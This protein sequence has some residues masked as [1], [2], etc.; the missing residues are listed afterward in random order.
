[1][2]A[3]RFDPQM[4]LL[5]VDLQNDFADPRGSLYVR[6]SERLVPVINDLVNEA[7]RRGALVV[8]TQDW[9]P[10]VTPHF[11]EFGGKWPAHCVAGTWGAAFVDGLRIEGPVLRKGTGEEDGYSA[12]SVQDLRTRGVRETPLYRM[13]HDRGILHVVVVGVAEEVCVRETA[14]DARR[15]GF[16]TTVVSAAVQPIDAAAE[17]RVHEELEAAG[18]EWT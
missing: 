1:M 5:V 12:F 18:V 13:L 11:R 16:P 15:L 4:V 2:N 14:L 8:Y 3:P 7:R 10:A 17:P 9:H 6:G